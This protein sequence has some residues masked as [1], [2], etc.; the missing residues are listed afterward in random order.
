MITS[1]LLYIIY[2]FLYAITSPLRLLN[3][4]SLSSDFTT[5]IQN[6]NEYLASLNFILPVSTFVAVI[7]LMLTIEG[8]IILY[9]I[10]NWVIRKIPTVN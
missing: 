8:F 1:A 2:L 4:V 9:K 3:D 10:I 7:A 6:A 5:A